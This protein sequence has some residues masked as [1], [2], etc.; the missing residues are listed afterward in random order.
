MT[1]FL[2]L[3]DGVSW[4]KV[5]SLASTNC[6]GVDTETQ[7]CKLEV[8][9]CRDIVKN[10]FG[11]QDEAA[12][13]RYRE[14]VK[15]ENEHN[16]AQL[17]T[18]APPRGHLIGPPIDEGEIYTRFYVRKTLDSLRA[19]GGPEMCRVWNECLDAVAIRLFNERP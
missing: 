11:S 5:L 6:P 1:D 3:P 12:L 19:V 2:S 17:T 18:K 7:T 16:A 8:C 4:R 9:E 13:R 10:I 14:N 15:K